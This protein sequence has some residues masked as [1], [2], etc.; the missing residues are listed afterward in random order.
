MKNNIDLKNRIYSFRIYE[1][2]EVWS[3]WIEIPAYNPEKALIKF[4][5]II[6]NWDRIDNQAASF[7]FPDKKHYLDL[8]N[9]DDGG[10]ILEWREGQYYTDPPKYT[11]SKFFSFCRKFIFYLI[12]N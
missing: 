10:V 5:K 8:Y 4:T 6:L 2:N 7:L 11:L 12:K 9:R 1:F 3:P